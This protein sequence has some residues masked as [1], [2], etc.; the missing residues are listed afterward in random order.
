MGSILT[1]DTKTILLLCG[2]FGEDRTVKVL[3]AAEYSALARWLMESGMRPCD[4]LRSEHVAAAAN[5]SGLAQ[6]RLEYLLGR[7][8]ELG[9]AVEEWERSGIWIVSRSDSD[10][11]QRCKQHLKDVT[12]PLFFCAGDRQLMQRRGIAIVGSR[13]VDGEGEEFT[14]QTASFCAANHIAVISGGARGVDQLA[15]NS[16]LESGGMVI[17]VL[18]DSLLKKSVERHARYALA[19]GRLLLMSPYNPTSPFSVGNAMGRNKLIYAMSDYGLVVHSDYKKGGTW[20]GAEE[21][22]KRKEA[23]PVF[24]HMA[25]NSPQGNKE[26]LGIGALPW[27]DDINQDNIKERLAGLLKQHRKKRE[28]HSVQLSFTLPSSSSD[29]KKEPEAEVQQLAPCSLYSVVLPVILKYLQQPVELDK[30][31]VML[32]VQKSQLN[33]WLKRAVEEGRVI[34]LMRPVR[35]QRCLDMTDGAVH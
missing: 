2:V 3:S 14:R 12:P 27:P 17:A 1:E 31:A 19:D 32:D 28:Q 34:R 22:L 18:A 10:Y 26:L 33:L 16:A 5:G 21:E 13:N 7:G 24:V 25:E 6:E 29:K 35:Y 11:P 8:I 15:M 23:R 4:L 20:S 9:F 30:L